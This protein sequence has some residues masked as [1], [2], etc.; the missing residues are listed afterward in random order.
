MNHVFLFIVAA[1]VVKF[2]IFG[3]LGFGGWFG[4]MLCMKRRKRER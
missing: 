1:V 4:S 2:M 3:F